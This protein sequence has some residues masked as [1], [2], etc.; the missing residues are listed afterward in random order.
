MSRRDPVG[1][2]LQRLRQE[3]AAHPLPPGAL[4]PGER[5]LA[6]VHRVSRQSVRKALERLAAEGLVE[7]RHG[8]GTR[9]GRPAGRVAGRRR[10]IWIG[11]RSSHVYR[12]IWL[13][14]LALAPA[15]GWQLEAP[16]TD[17]GIQV[18]DAVLCQSILVDGLAARLPAGTPLVAF[19]VGP[20]QLSV[21]CRLVCADRSEA[22]RQ[23]VRRLR[24]A[25]HRRIVL[26]RHQTGSEAPGAWR[27]D[28]LAQA[29]VGELGDRADMMALQG[30][31]ETAE[32]PL[33]AKLRRRD[34]PSALVCDMDYT[35]AFAY[36]AAQ[37]AHLQVP[38][39]LSLVGLGA[40]PW[41]LAQQP[42]LTSICFQPQALAEML[43]AAAS[44]PPPAEPQ[45]WMVQPRLVEGGSVGPV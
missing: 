38:H 21:A 9:L 34:R 36:A 44:L 18:D 30:I 29:F 43:L 40:T 2:V 8:S 32:L 17:V 4:L 37:R 14:A 35:A 12:E 19:G 25:G 6:R 26:V 11:E 41:S 23:A 1:T 33:V 45:T 16:A 31:G 22:L 7:R 5:D 13:R 10:L 20:Q 24:H 28:Y 42:V 27:D 3:L 39:D 15:L